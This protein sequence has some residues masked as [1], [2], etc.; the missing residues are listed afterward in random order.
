MEPVHGALSS[1]VASHGYHVTVSCDPGYILSG[2]NILVCS[3]GSWSGN[4]GTCVEDKGRYQ[5][6]KFECNTVKPILSGH[7][8][9]IP[10]IG[11]QD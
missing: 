10:N 2:D 3:S 8:Q 1:K 7:A 4:V 5:L 9:R 11:F 6:H